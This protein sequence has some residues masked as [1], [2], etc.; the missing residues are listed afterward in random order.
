MTPDKSRQTGMMRWADPSAK[1]TL[2]LELVEELGNVHRA[3]I[4]ATINGWISASYD[5]TV[6][7]AT[8]PIPLTPISSDLRE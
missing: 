1:P 8:V 4:E 5:V 7:A 2:H 3:Y 6:A